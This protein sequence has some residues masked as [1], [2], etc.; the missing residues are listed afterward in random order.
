MVTNGSPKRPSRPGR[1]DRRSTRTPVSAP[2]RWPRVPICWSSRLC[3]TLPGPAPRRSARQVRRTAVAT[4]HRHRIRRSPGNQLRTCTRAAGQRRRGCPHRPQHPHRGAG[5]AGHGH[6]ELGLADRTRRRQDPGRPGHGGPGR[7][8]RWTRCGGTGRTPWPGR[9]SAPMS[10]TLHLLTSYGA[11]QDIDL[12]IGDD[13]FVSRF[14]VTTEKP[15]I[16]SWQDVDTA[17][18][19]TGARYSWQVSK[20]ND[21][22]CEKVAGTNTAESLPLA[23]IFKTYVLY[24]VERRRTGRHFALGRQTHHHGRRQEARHRRA[25]TSCH[26]A[27]RS[28]CDRR[29][30]R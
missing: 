15:K 20:V 16:D 17:L 28:R 3:W 7:A 5:Q 18:S 27:R 8:Q 4:R 11:R 6:A 25:S 12:R 10:A 23:S 2:I 29:R 1:P 21:G 22:R 9:T 13:T 24:A 19:R 30:A 26:P 14:V